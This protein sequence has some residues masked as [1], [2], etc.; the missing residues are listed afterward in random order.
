MSQHM[1]QA[2]QNRVIALRT[3][4]ARNSDPSDFESTPFVSANPTTHITPWQPE[5]C[6]A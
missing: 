2:R 3:V 6:A 1:L 4:A 5:E